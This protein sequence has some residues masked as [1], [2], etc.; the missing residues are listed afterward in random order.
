MSLSTKRLRHRI[1]FHEDTSADGAEDPTYSSFAAA[2]P[3]DVKPVTGSE[4]YLGKQLQAETNFAIL[5]RWRSDVDPSMRIVNDETSV[6]YEINRMIDLD[7]R[8]HFWLIEAT[9][10]VI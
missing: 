8:Q 7:G 10:V 6:N 5:T 4:R 2:I 9:E 1:T 3:A